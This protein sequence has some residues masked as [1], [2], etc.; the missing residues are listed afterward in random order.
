MASLDAGRKIRQVMPLLEN[1]ADMA[2]ELSPD[3]DKLGQ[4][5][6]VKLGP[7][8]PP[9]APPSV[10]PPQMQAPLLPG[11]PAPQPPEGPAPEMQGVP[12]GVMGIAVQLEMLLPQIASADPSLGSVIT[13]FLSKLRQE[14]PKILEGERNNGMNPPPTDEMLARLPAA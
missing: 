4:S 2:P 12:Q 6:V 1:L 11:Q 7:S 3:I 5:L 14:V 13:G 8:G 10:G 9:T